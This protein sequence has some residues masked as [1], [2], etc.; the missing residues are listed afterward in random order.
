MW[1]DY[2]HEIG[3]LKA[4]FFVPDF[5]GKFGFFLLNF[6]IPSYIYFKLQWGSPNKMLSQW[7]S[8]IPSENIVLQQHYNADF[9]DT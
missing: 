1:K 3:S 2:D 4:T 6:S 5:T 7:D 8:P 9:S